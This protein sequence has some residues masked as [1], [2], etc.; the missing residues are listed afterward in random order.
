MTLYTGYSSARLSFADE[1]GNG[2]TFREQTTI[3]PQASVT[4]G[5]STTKTVLAQGSSRMAQNF[6]FDGMEDV[7]FDDYNSDIS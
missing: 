1:Y 3:T 6:A 7:T 5:T 4:G 2:Y